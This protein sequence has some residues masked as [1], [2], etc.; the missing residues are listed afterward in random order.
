MIFTT[1]GGWRVKMIELSKLRTAVTAFKSANGILGDS[2]QSMFRQPEHE[3]NT[4]AARAGLSMRPFVPTNRGLRRFGFTGRLRSTSTQTL[5]REPAMPSLLQRL[6]RKLLRVGALFK[7]DYDNI[8]YVYHV[9]CILLIVYSHWCVSYVM[10][11]CQRLCL[12]YH[13]ISVYIVFIVFS[14]SC[15]VWS[16]S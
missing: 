2:L 3:H 13:C 15:W 1:F 4:R 11:I 6:R 14:T 8:A 9:P 5:R 16:L 10:Q 12:F 7:T